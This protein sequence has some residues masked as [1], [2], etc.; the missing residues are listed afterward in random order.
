VPQGDSG[1]TLMLCQEEE[2]MR[3][4]LVLGEAGKALPYVGSAKSNLQILYDELK[5]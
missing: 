3:R 5:K 1:D 4:E 2:F